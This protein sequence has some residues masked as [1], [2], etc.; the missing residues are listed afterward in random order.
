M[1]V[2]FLS[3]L[4]WFLLPAI[5]GIAVVMA[6]IMAVAITLFSQLVLIIVFFISLSPIL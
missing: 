4:L 3:W 5:A 6:I 2:V 1:T